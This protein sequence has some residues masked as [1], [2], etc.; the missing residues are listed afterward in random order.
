MTRIPALAL[1]DFEHLGATNRAHT[2]GRRLAILHGNGLGILH[3]FLGAA[4]HTVSLH[5][6]SPSLIVLAKQAITRTRSCQ[7]YPAYGIVYFWLTGF[8]SEYIILAP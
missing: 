4:L 5:F 7:E 1:P 8:V 6:T 2:L 3:F